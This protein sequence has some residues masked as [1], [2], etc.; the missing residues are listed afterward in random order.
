MVVDGTRVGLRIILP[1]L[2]PLI[3][4]RPKEGSHGGEEDPGPGDP[5]KSSDN[6]K[7]ILASFILP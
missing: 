7:I 5:D 2:Q 1:P 4:P 3:R 6:N